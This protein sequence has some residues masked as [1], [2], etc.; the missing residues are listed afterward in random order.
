MLPPIWRTRLAAMAGSLVAIVLAIQIANG[1]LAWS[2]V[3]AFALIALMW[4]RVQELPFGALLLGLVTFGYIVGSRGF[5]QLSLS[6]TLPLLPAESVLLVTGALLAVGSALRRS[7]PVRLDGLNLAIL[8]WMLL[9]S[10]RLYWDVRI[11]GAS[12]LRDY[13]MV[14]YAAFFFLGQ[15]AA[16]RPIS[17]RFFEAC[18]LIGCASLAVTYPLFVRWPDFFV[19]RLSIAGVPVI[20]YKADLAG[21]FLAVGSVM[22]YLR[23]ETR[24]SWFALALS[25]LLA[26]E[27]LITDNR[28]SMLGLLAAALLLILAGRWRLACIQAIAGAIAAVVI[29]FA[30][31]LQ[32][33]TWH[34]TPVYGVYQ[35]VVSLADPFGHQTYSGV[36][37]ANKGDNNLFRMVWWRTV[38]DDTVANG[39]WTGLGY[40]YDLAEQFLQEY[41][42]GQSEEFNARSPHNVMLTMFARTGLLGAVPFAVVVLIILI[43][44]VRVS[45]LDLEAA[46]LWLTVCTIFVAA[47]FGVVLEGPMGAVV[48]WTALGMANASTKK[49]LA[50]SATVDVTAAAAPAPAA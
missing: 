11:Y 23:Y 29:V 7:L 36:D 27:T 30:A 43:R 15:D 26:G 20:Y 3:V 40:G 37:A 33:R 45:R 49:A 25:L 44:A 47:C 5:A 35:R 16:E 31:Y 1:A 2:M 28:A 19:E 14:Y 22:M 12:A 38:Y 9:A 10:G 17:R 34:D 4:G 8:L 21:T 42:G 13:A 46:G 50:E 41:Y 18:L 39:R 32:N 24:R 48:F 6:R